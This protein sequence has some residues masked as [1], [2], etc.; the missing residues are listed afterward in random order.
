VNRPRI[1]V[2]CELESGK[3]RFGDTKLL[4]VNPDYVRAVARA[5]ATPV[6]LPV[7]TRGGEVDRD[8]LQDQLA[9]IDGLVLVGGDDMDPARYGQ[10]PHTS[11]VPL[12]PERDAYDFALATAAW[13]RGLPILGV[14]GGMQLLAVA[15]GGSLHQHLPA[16]LGTRHAELVPVHERP[17]LDDLLH[18]VVVHPGTT[19]HAILGVDRLETNSRHHQAV[20]RLGS[21]LRVAAQSRDGVVEAVEASDGRFV[22]GV[23]WHPEERAADDASIRLFTALCREA[24][25]RTA[26]RPPR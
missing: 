9:A 6:L 25:H 1:G 26:S 8:A 11:I 12:D 16:T 14:C 4:S 24:A 2:N 5:G 3:R 18:E 10:E 23:Q 7:T 19:L 20:D 22:L 15:S 17:E 13:E 21:A